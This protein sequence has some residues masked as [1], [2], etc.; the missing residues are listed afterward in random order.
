MTRRRPLSILG[1]E[2]RYVARLY[3]VQI[4]IVTILVLGLVLA[5][6]LA[7]RFDR[8]LTAQG[9]EE[10][11]EGVLRILYYLTLR[12]AYNLPAILPIA[13]AVGIIWIEFRL[14]R[15]HERSMIANTGRATSLSLVPSLLVGLLIGSIQFTLVASI[16]PMAVEAQGVAGFRNYGPRFGEY[17]SAPIW[18]DVDGTILRTRIRHT[19]E[20]PELIDLRLFGFNADNRLV[21][22]AWADGARAT[23]T[24]LLLLGE[25]GGWLG[26]SQQAD[27]VPLTINPDWLSYAGVSPRFL[28]QSSLARIAAAQDGVPTQNAYRAALQERWASLALGPALAILVSLLSMT[29]M[30]P[31]VRPAVPLGIAAVSYAVHVGNSAISVLGEYERLPPAI[32]AWGLPVTILL[33]CGA[34]VVARES[35]VRRQLAT[36]RLDG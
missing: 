27:R 2:T 29:L 15:S 21:Q 7:G 5:L 4:L 32:S 9:R 6:D 36:L 13:T 28:P 30:A 33:V 8:I 23:A 14:A 19:A 26:A 31:R 20:G 18:M 25:N 3:I 11:P 17:I 35:R 22:V 16:R 34:V 24:D 1:R 10:L 12:A